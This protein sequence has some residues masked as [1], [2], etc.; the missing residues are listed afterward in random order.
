LTTCY[1]VIAGAGH[2]DTPPDTP[3]HAR[4]LT[5]DFF[6]K[7]MAAAPEASPESCGKICALMFDFISIDCHGDVYICC[8]FPNQPSLRIGSYLDLSA[9]EILLRR[10]THSF[11]KG[12]TGLD[13]RPRILTSAGYVAQL[14]VLSHRLHLYPYCVGSHLYPLL[15][16][17]ISSCSVGSR[18]S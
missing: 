9:Q 11:C 13:A 7:Q 16:S 17:R 5:D 4:S 1:E 14:G 12:C 8:A 18:G 2:P 3:F 10:W 6:R 15:H